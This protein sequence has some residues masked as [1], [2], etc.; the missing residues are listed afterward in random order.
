MLNGLA[1]VIVVYFLFAAMLLPLLT[2][3]GFMELM[4]TLLR[5]SFRTVFRLP[6]RSAIDALAS[7]MGSSTVGVLIT[8][9]QYRSGFYTQREASVIATNFSIVSVAFC[10]VIA[11][12]CGVDHVF[13]QYYLSVVVAGLIAAVVTCRIPPL[14]SRK[15]STMLQ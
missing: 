9:Q 14:S 3:F 7:W 12:F 4:G 1:S 8:T 5:N 2:D 10:L 13:P 6:G 11:K 15:I